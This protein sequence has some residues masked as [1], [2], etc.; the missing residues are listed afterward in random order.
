MGS[1]ACS[2]EGTREKTSACTHD[3]PGASRTPAGATYLGRV[4][5]HFTA[6]SPAFRLLAITNGQHLTRLSQVLEN[7]S[8]MHET[9]QA[10]QELD[11]ESTGFVSWKDGVVQQMVERI[12]Q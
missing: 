8:L 11:S 6:L 7:G 1:S 9:F 4:H 5:V 2:T 3:S 12:F 10:F